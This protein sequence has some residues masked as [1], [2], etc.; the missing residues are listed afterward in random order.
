MEMGFETNT[1]DYPGARSLSFMASFLRSL[2]WWELDPHPELVTENASRYCAA[3]PGKRY[4]VY[5]RW[6]GAAKI[7]L[8]RS[9]EQDSFSYEWLDLADAKVRDGGVVHGGAVRAFQAPG[10]SPGTPQSK[11]WVLYIHRG[12]GKRG[13]WSDRA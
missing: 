3:I 12:G 4:I 7:D 11:D 1:L 6:G 13:K 9:S 8:C 5:L 10:D 2:P